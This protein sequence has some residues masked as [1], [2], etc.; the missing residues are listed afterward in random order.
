[1][2]KI[3]AF[4]LL[5]CLLLTACGETNPPAEMN[6]SPSKTTG[7]TV[8]TTVPTSVS[9]TDPATTTTKPTGTTTKPTGTSGTTTKPT[10][11]PGTTTKP[12]GT[13]VTTI[14][15]VVPAPTTSVP[16]PPRLII[17]DYSEYAEYVKIEELPGYF[18]T[19]DKMPPLG[20]F[21]KFSVMKAYVNSGTYECYYYQFAD[22]FGTT[23]GMTV[24]HVWEAET[25]T[26]EYVYDLDGD[27]RELDNKEKATKYYQH[28]DLTYCYLSGE[29]YTIEWVSNNIRF[30]LNVDQ[31]S[32][33]DG[34]GN[35]AEPEFIKK[36]LH[37][38]TVDAGMQMFESAMAGK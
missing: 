22:D 27:L 11:T 31:Y 2:K 38:D 20:D 10:G 30:V 18:V 26:K 25:S 35:D 23:I 13:T 29:I 24:Y 7:T 1:M 5:A 16:T 37:T 32:R 9:S 33:T 36:L 12:T 28:G 3:V 34:W 4:G 21:K 8:S 14:Q 6:S 15:P 17:Y 19:L